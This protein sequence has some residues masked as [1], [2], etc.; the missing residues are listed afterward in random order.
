MTRVTV[1]GAGSWGTTLGNLLAGE[2]H[3]VSMWAYEPEVA[4][5]ITERN[6]N[7][8]FLSGCPLEPSLRASSDMHEALEGVEVVVSAVPSHAVRAVA[9]Q[10]ASVLDDARPQPRPLVVSVSKGLEEESLKMMSDVL[11]ETLPDTPIAA[12]SGPS[13]AREVYQRH[14]TAVVVACRDQEAAA[15]AQELFRSSYFRVYTSTDVV[16]VQLGGALKNVIAIAAGLL[17][18]LELGH[19]S[20]AALVTRG[21]AETTRLGVTMGAD[22]MTFAGLAGIGDLLLTATGGLSRNRTL[23]IELAKGRSLDEIMAERNTVAEG[24]LTARAAVE[25]AQREGTE[26]P[27]AIEVSKILFDGKD[28]T[29]AVRDLMERE[30]KPERWQ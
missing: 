6:V 12:L 24:V 2:G 22:P 18:G 21:L 9:G 17:H 28:P 1:M 27:I 4:A 11:E 8:D 13:F 25:L 15:T 26:L 30:P 7:E 19:N 29:L 3:D 5:S 20:L 23:G 16:G 14:P 10:V